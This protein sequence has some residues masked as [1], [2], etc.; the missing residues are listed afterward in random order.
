M[1]DFLSRHPFPEIQETRNEQ[2][3]RADVEVDHAVVMET[4]K[5]QLKTITH[6]KS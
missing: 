5:S 6:Y 4:I 3:V 1:T 2:Y